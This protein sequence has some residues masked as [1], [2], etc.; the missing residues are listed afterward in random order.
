MSNKSELVFYLYLI[1]SIVLDNNKTE[2]GSSIH[3]VS[4]EYDEGKI[5]FQ[6][7]TTIEVGETV[8][9]LTAKIQVLEHA[10]FPVIIE[11]TIHHEFNA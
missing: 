10:Y 6:K 2:S 8:N 3:Y 11:K 5:L 7:S 9:S 4:N 1:K